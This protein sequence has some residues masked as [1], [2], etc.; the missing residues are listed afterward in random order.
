MLQLGLLT[1]PVK[2]IF[3]ACR[4]LQLTDFAREKLLKI[5]ITCTARDTYLLSGLLALIIRQC[6][7]LN[8]YV[9]VDVSPH[10]SLVQSISPNLVP[11]KFE[12]KY[13]ASNQAQFFTYCNCRL[14]CSQLIDSIPVYTPLGL[15]ARYHYKL[16]SRYSFLHRRF[17]KWKLSK[18]ASST[19]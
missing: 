3:L 13:G 17:L 11:S 19:G 1:E 15:F 7:H 14:W 6:I 2:Q 5:S 10:F 16:F 8:M 12:Q 18:R 9:Q 4:T